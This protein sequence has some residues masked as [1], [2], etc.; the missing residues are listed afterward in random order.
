MRHFLISACLA[1]CL[2]SALPGVAA[3]P[4]E[5]EGGAKFLDDVSMLLSYS[6]VLCKDDVSEEDRAVMELIG[7]ILESPD[8]IDAVLRNYMQLRSKYMDEAVMSAAFQSGKDLTE[9]EVC[10][11]LRENLAAL[12]EQIRGMA[13]DGEK[14]KE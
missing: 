1:C 7:R 12:L 3:T 2:M 10:K 14:K 6:E 5:A 13:R 11:G 4:E 8:D 9:H